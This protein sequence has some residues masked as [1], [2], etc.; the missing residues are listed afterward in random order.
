MIFA[1]HSAQAQFDLAPVTGADTGLRGDNSIS[2]TIFTI[3]TFFAGLLASL[4][5]LFIVIAGILY[6]TSS[7]DS[8][9]VDRAKQMLTYAIIGLIVALLAWVIVQSIAAAL[10]AG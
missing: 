8:G 7:G 9:R 1:A 6:I 3:I 10:G 2:E 5:I 4:A